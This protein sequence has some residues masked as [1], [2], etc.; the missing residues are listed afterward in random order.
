MIKFPRG[1]K[2]NTPNVNLNNPNRIHNN[3]FSPICFLRANIP[4]IP[5]NFT[6]IEKTSITTTNAA[7]ADGL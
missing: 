5:D 1:D 2:N 6:S 4:R 7:G 3:E